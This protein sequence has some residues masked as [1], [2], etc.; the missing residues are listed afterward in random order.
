MKHP[1]IFCIYLLWGLIIPRE[2]KTPP[3]SRL[4]MEK[5]RPRDPGGLFRISPRGNTQASR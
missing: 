5:L 3:N 2:N 1:Y 4:Q